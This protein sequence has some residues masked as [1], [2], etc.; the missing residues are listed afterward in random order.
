M[1]AAEGWLIDRQ[2]EAART[3]QRTALGPSVRAP[4]STSKGG[5]RPYRKII[6][7]FDPTARQQQ[8][9]SRPARRLLCLPPPNRPRDSA[10]AAGGG[11]GKGG[12]GGGGDGDRQSG[13]GRAA[14]A[15]SADRGDSP[16]H[17]VAFWR[18]C[19]RPSPEGS[20]DDVITWHGV[21]NYDRGERSTED[22]ALTGRTLPTMAEV[23]A[24]AR[25][26]GAG[27]WATTRAGGTRGTNMPSR[28]RQ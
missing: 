15:G 17:H 26:H 10:R 20:G 25:V 6:A 8:Y 4:S 18:V 7:L 1:A 5:E 21:G 28:N 11:G 27:S 22:S 19:T 9:R 3:V 24:A 14:A 16:A 2:T 23:E 13:G 12:G